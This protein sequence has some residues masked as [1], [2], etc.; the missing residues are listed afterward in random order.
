M[1]SVKLKLTALTIAFLMF[2][3]VVYAGMQLLAVF[4]GGTITV[5][6]IQGEILYSLDNSNWTKDINMSIPQD[7]YVNFTTWL[8]NGSNNITVDLNWSLFFKNNNTVV[9]NYTTENVSISTTP[10]TYIMTIKD[11]NFTKGNQYIVKVEVLS[12]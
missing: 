6:T 4:Y 8:E 12:P 5:G 9:W 10:T 11:G 2:V 3:A 7:L 1:K